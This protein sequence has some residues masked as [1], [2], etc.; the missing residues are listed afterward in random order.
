[1]RMSNEEWDDVIAVNLTATFVLCRAAVRN[2]MRRRYGRIINIASIVAVAPEPHLQ[3]RRYC[4][5]LL[6][7]ATPL[8]QAA[9]Y[10]DV[11]IMRQLVAA[12]ANPRFAAAD[13]STILIAAVAA[14]SGFGTGD[15]RERYLGPGDIAPTPEEMEAAN[16]H[17]KAVALKR[18]EDEIPKLT[19]ELESIREKLKST[20]LDEK[21]KRKLAFREREIGKKLDFLLQETNREANTILS[22]SAELAIC[23]AAI[24]VKTEV[25]KLREQAQNVE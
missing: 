7:V 8:W 18:I 5:T 25:E 17:F 11:R 10:G 15:R 19:A 9:R 2:M 24:E 16:A 21:E 12:G 4:R 6:E 1:M 20:A 22:K 14:N 3:W 13:G 23:D